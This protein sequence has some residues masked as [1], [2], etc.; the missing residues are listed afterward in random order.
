M[1]KTQAQ[2]EQR[3]TTTDFKSLC[4][5]GQSQITLIETFFAGLTGLRITLVETLHWVGN[6]LI[7]H[8]VPPNY[9]VVSGLWTKLKAFIYS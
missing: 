6:M 7:I 8:S 2:G 4:P 1:K 3:L 5:L 9:R